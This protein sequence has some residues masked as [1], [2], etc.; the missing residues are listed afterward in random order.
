VAHSKPA[1]SLVEGPGFGLSGDVHARVKLRNRSD[2]DEDA[3]PS[4]PATNS[5]LIDC[6]GIYWGLRKAPGVSGFSVPQVFGAMFLS[7]TSAF[8]RTEPLPFF[9]ADKGLAIGHGSN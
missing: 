9:R 6:M 5:A 3:F 8:P 7:P 2:I 4:L 1:L